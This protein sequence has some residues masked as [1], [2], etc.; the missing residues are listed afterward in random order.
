MQP[1]NRYGNFN[2]FFVLIEDNLDSYYEF[3]Y[4]SN[5]QLLT[6]TFDLSKADPLKL[7]KSFDD[8]LKDAGFKEFSDEDN[9]YLFSITQEDKKWY[10]SLE[11]KDNVLDSVSNLFTDLCW[12]NFSH[13][14]QQLVKTYATKIDIHQFED[15]AF[16]GCCYNRDMIMMDWF[17]NKC[18]GY[19]QNPAII[20]T[21]LPELL[22][23]G[24]IEFIEWLEKLN[25]SQAVLL[26]AYRIVAPKRNS[27]ALHA[28]LRD[29]FRNVE[30][31]K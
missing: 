28:K 2:Q 23:R 21:I 12:H 14:A 1:R 19:F 8:L 16:K 18:P 24:F 31:P 3:T 29:V 10:L 20:V 26:E 6:C 9:K 4:T 25:P 22:N 5:N 15:L 7:S 30:F 11:I 27:D 13:I 17:F